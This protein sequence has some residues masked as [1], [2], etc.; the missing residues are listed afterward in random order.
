[1]TM[2]LQSL[3]ADRQIDAQK[4]QVEMFRAETDRMKANSDIAARMNPT[5]GA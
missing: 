5:G 2:Q 1:M 3:Q 4:L